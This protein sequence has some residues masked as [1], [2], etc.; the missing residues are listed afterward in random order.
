MNH[1]GSTRISKWVSVLLLLSTLVV[2]LSAASND[3]EPSAAQSQSKPSG[4]SIGQT[5]FFAGAHAGM[6]FPNAASDLFSFVTR[7]LTLQKSDF[8]A[9]LFGFDFGVTFQSH[10]AAV[11]AIEYSK[12][13]PVSEFRHFVDENGN[14]IVQT[15]NFSQLPIVGT[16]RYYP[17]KSGESVG[18]YVWMPRRFNPY[19]A[20]GGGLM[21]YDFRQ[22]GSFVNSK[23]LD[24]VDDT[25]ESDGFAPAGH[26]AGGFDINFSKRF[27]A[28]FEARY[29]FSHKHL[30]QD[31]TSFKPIDLWGFRP[32]GGFGVR[33]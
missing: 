24:I 3:P 18:S 11:F 25:L 17:F 5:R 6:T 15:T 8:Q 4:F 27:F 28:N 30:S 9:P 2:S 29:V 13:S 33:F 23:T 14:S 32:T 31:F 19:I 22:A 21:R 7:D 20:A 12:A 1:I 26:L 16:L 10:F